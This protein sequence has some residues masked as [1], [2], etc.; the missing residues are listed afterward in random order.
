MDKLALDNA[1]AGAVLLELANLGRVTPAEEDDNSKDDRLIVRDSSSTGD[2]VLDNGLSRLEIKPIK[3]KRAVE[4]LVKGTRDAVLD[5]LVERGLVRREESKVLGMFP[6][7]SW[8]VT[9]TEHENEVRD[10]L[11][12]VL[13]RGEDPDAHVGGL[14]ALLNAVGAI[15]K[16]VEGN[17]KELKAR[18]KE[19]AEGEWAG[20]A[21]KQAITKV[22][23]T[24][25]AA[26]VVSVA[27]GS[28]ASN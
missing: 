1:V 18:A 8:P 3:G 4:L 28:A 27:A 7:K 2:S 14:V 20:A 21:V 17:K 26:I 25:T 24:I 23:A 6:R 22:Q 9:D 15:H 19:V 12:A 16:V 5:R 13:L 11:N 10:R